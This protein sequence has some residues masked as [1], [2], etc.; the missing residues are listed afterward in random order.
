MTTPKKT[1]D[2]IEIPPPGPDDVLYENADV[3]ARIVLNRPTILNAMNKNVQRLLLAAFE[4]AEADDDV[5]AVV[6]TGAGRAFSA[7][8]DLYA[9]LYPD[10]EPAPSGFDVQMKIW[11]FPKPVIAAVRGHAVG[12]ACELAGVCDFIIA[13]EG[14]RFGE[15]HIR[16]GFPPPVLITPFLVSMKNAKE[17]L[18]LGEQIDAREAHRMG[19]VNR[20]VPPEALDA[21]A[22]TMA[23]K[24]AALPQTTVRLNKLLVNRA[25]ELMGLREAIA[26]RDV[27]E[28]AAIADATRGD[29]VATSRLALLHEAG[30]S[31]FLTTRDAM[32]RERPSFPSQPS[33][34]EGESA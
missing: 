14:A 5:K 32:Y 31:A 12:Q 33:P 22:E 29:E 23:R 11:S 17:L 15:I 28:I 30:W 19:L 34:I 16:H 26:Y 7:G 3:Y 1:P 25:Y 2:G 10:D 6:L 27:P 18:M 20:V 9:Y 24:L 4:R 13:A 21:E 8:G